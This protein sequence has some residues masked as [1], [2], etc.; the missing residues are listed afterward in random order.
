MSIS[1]AITYGLGYAFS[2]LPLRVLYVISDVLLYPLCYYVI[3]YRKKLIK[4][5]LH[6]SFPEKTDA[7]V[8]RLMKQFFHFFCD[9]I[10]ETIKLLSMSKKQMMRRMTFSGL[11]DVVRTLHE[12]NK[13]FC[14]FYLGHY[15]NWEWIASLAYWAPE[16]IKCA[17]IYHPLKNKAFDKLF[18]DMRNHFGGKSIPMKETL[19]EIITMRRNNQKTIVGFISDQAPKMENI[20]HWTPF[21]NHDTPVFVGT[22][23]IGKQVDAT[24]WIGEMKRV[25]RGY[26]HCHIKL[27]DDNV[28]GKPD[29]EITDHCTRLL[30]E[31]IK[32]EPQFWLWSHNRWKRDK[33]EW[34][35]LQEELKNKRKE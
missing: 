23:K 6:D 3:G 19:R 25:K 24:V 14:F 12:Q 30:E 13:L 8:N 34:L 22:E 9:Y 35:R 20:H 18:L 26:Y 4:K 16:D 17:Q 32:Q 27:V 11:D 28:K 15:G 29:Y 21:L 31:M 10:V 7:E 33:N 5:N 2:L 1:Y